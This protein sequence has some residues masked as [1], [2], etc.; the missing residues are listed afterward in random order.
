MHLIKQDK[1]F[2]QYKKLVKVQL[3]QVSLFTIY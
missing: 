2:D 3:W 1:K